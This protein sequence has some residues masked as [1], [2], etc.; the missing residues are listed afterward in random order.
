MDV[1]WLCL[2]NWERWLLPIA[3]SVV[4][5]IFWPVRLVYKCQPVCHGWRK[6]GGG[7]SFP[8]NTYMYS[9]Q[10]EPVGTAEWC[11]RINLADLTP[12]TKFLLGKNNVHVSCVRVCRTCTMAM[13]SSSAGTF[14]LGTRLPACVLHSSVSVISTLSCHLPV[15]A[16][17][18]QPDPVERRTYHPRKCVYAAV[19]CVAP[20]VHVRACA[21]PI[22]KMYFEPDLQKFCAAKIWSYRVCHSS[23]THSACQDWVDVLSCSHCTLSHCKWP[24]FLLAADTDVSSS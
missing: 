15:D 8:F 4:K 2:S 23:F 9:I 3:P 5:L 16:K 7:E 10:G 19:T 24:S 22:P 18:N 21:V 20:Y 6:C 13:V 12:S 11:Q 1:G 14:L 17:V